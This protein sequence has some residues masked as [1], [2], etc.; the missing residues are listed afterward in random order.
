MFIERSP[1]IINQPR[2]GG[3]D[4]RVDVAG[5]HAAPP[6]L[7]RMGEGGYYKQVVPNGASMG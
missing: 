4:W 5:F 2:R 1:P 6:G 7:I 3:M